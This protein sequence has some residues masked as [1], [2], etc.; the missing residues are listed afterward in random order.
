MKDILISYAGN[1][2]MHKPDLP[3]KSILSHAKGIVYKL[4]V[5]ADHEQKVE[6]R[7]N[8]SS[9]ICSSESE[10]EATDSVGRRKIFEKVIEDY[11]GS[12]T[13]SFH[14]SIAKAFMDPEN[15]AKNLSSDLDRFKI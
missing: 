6:S 5:S 13:N 10:S 7:D 9:I 1:M 15:R 3:P 14:K 11:L 4:M 8:T 2:R 12:E